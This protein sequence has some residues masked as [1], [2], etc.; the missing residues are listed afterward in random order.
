MVGVDKT[1]NDR[2]MLYS[3]ESKCEKR[4]IIGTEAQMFSTQYQV[5]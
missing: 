5:F 4:L 3:D 1:S 2:V